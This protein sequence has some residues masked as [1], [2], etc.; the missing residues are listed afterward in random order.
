[1]AQCQ[2]K[3]LT[4]EISALIISR[5]LGMRRVLFQIMHFARVGC[6]LRC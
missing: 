6:F 5:Y 3:F 4:Y 1:M 2:A